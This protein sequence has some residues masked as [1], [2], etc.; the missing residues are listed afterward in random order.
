MCVLPSGMLGAMLSDVWIMAQSLV[1]IA[2]YFCSL[3]KKSDNHSLFLCTVWVKFIWNDQYHN[4]NDCESDYKPVHAVHMSGW[5]SFLHHCFFKEICLL[6]L[7]RHSGSPAQTHSTCWTRIWNGA[8]WC[9]FIYSMYFYFIYLFF[10]LIVILDFSVFVVL[11]QTC[12]Y[13]DSKRLLLTLRSEYQE[14]RAIVATR[15][16]H[17]G[18]VFSTKPTT[19]KVSKQYHLKPCCSLTWSGSCWDDWKQ[20]RSL[21]LSSTL[22]SDGWVYLGEYLTCWAAGLQS[23]TN[24]RKCGCRT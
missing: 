12:T 3:R 13:V 11:S 24:A 19:K 18:C 4:N 21:I 14:G 2:T 23:G 6:P 17:V 1:H 22:L 16:L 9:Y 10:E 20:I 8:M 7:V 15:R 5:D